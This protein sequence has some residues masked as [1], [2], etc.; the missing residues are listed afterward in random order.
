ML[1]KTLVD[2]KFVIVCSCWEYLNPTFTDMYFKMYLLILYLDLV[3][4]YYKV[5]R[6]RHCLTVLQIFFFFFFYVNP[7]LYSNT[8]MTRN[9]HW[10]SFTT[11]DSNSFLSPYEILL[12]AQE[13]RYLGKFSFF[14]LSWNCM[15]CVHTTC[16]YCVE[17]K[18]KNFPKLSPLL[19]DLVPWLI[20][21]GLNYPCLE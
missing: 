6:Y 16:H 14:F 7:L 21:S 13:N 12:K 10:C 18:K 8:S 19:P 9:T 1:I 3:L 11:D 5:K 2:N 17:D 4:Y 20:I 15:L